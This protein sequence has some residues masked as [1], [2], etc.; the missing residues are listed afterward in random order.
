MMPLVVEIAAVFVAG[1]N[2]QVES[3]ARETRSS[4]V[5][6]NYPSRSNVSKFV[7][8]RAVEKRCDKYTTITTNHDVIKNTE[9]S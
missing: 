3:S 4:V 6:E 7:A 5:V 2:K 9:S 1:T 8:V